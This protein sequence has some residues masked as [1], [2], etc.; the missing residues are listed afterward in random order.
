[1]ITTMAGKFQANLG[2]NP[3]ALNA[4]NSFTV[5]N[6]VTQVAISQAVAPWAFVFLSPWTLIL[7]ALQRA[8]N[9]KILSVGLRLPYHFISGVTSPEITIVGT[10]GIAN[11]WAL[12]ATGSDVA[13]GSFHLPDV[14]YEYSINQYFPWPQTG[15]ISGFDSMFLGAFINEFDVSMIGV[16][17]LLNTE[18]LYPEPFI[19]IEHTLPLL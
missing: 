7:S 9:F 1:M 6:A 17:A 14:N 4:Y 13:N 2:G 5:N 11:P 8:D 12:V 16:D 3:A 19:K 18:V 10:D 15:V